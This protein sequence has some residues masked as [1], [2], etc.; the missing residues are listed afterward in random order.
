MR[1]GKTILTALWLSTAV[2]AV[3]ATSY[4]QAP[5]EPTP[6]SERDSAEVARHYEEGVAAAKLTQWAKAYSSFLAAWKLKQ[7]YQI[8]ANLGRAELK[9]GKYRD[10]AE[11]LAYF[12]REASGV[13][14]D[15]RQT[16]QALLDEAR[17]KVGALTILVDR[18]EAEV[19]VDG[20]AV[21]K[22][23]LKREVFVEPGRRTV[24]AKLG[25]FGEDR[26]TLD[27]TAGSSP[28]VLLTLSPAS[29]RKAAPLA[30]PPATPPKALTPKD[31]DGAEEN[32]GQAG[33]ALIVTGAAL[34][35][36][37]A[38]VGV[39]SLVIA[40]NHG[41]SAQMIQDACLNAPGT[42]ACVGSH[43][44]EFNNHANN[45]W[46]LNNLAFWSFI[47]A[48]AAAAGTLIYGLAR[49]SAARKAGPSAAVLVGSHGGGVLIT[50]SW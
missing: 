33:T 36:V 4:G 50:T 18:S 8:A 13:T 21:G 9:L 48:G 17:A 3:A 45:E 34:S 43:V 37:A 6:M 26:R 1:V 32:T 47:G 25:G 12:L 19:L 27:V 49:P 39:V 15:E 30:Q 2:T 16:A 40:N 20:I 42:D 14:T 22:S 11:H 29:A 5:P 31:T 46:R 35:A 7:H 23:P 41:N 44:D 10:A 28:R 38:G 24:E